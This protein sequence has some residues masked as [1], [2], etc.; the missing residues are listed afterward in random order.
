MVLDSWVKIYYKWWFQL[1][2]PPVRVVFRVSRAL[3]PFFLR[4]N[5]TMAEIGQYP[6]L[7][8]AKHGPLLT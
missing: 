8:V 7:M 1:S 6:E 5:L 3:G 4:L 2:K